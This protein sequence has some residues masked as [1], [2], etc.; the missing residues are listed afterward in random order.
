MA[1]PQQPELRRSE[2]I[3]A[4]S[5]DA[6]EALQHARRPPSTTSEHGPIPESNRAG[7]HDEHEQDK[8][9]LDAFAERLGIVPASDAS[10]DAEVRTEVRTD[11]VVRSD[12]DADQARAGGDEPVG[13]LDPAS[14]AP[15]GLD[16][17]RPDAAARAADRTLPDRSASASGG[18]PGWAVV[19]R[20]G[21]LV[22]LEP[23]IVAGRVAERVR[24]VVESR[25]P[26]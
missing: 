25:L 16:A 10:S 17:P 6:T 26:R 7:H 9:D 4:L 12:E 8:P 18:P 2:R 24:E 3:E 19:A 21:A 23:W 14:D 20:A 5:P 15:P 22:V 13:V 11:A 1:N